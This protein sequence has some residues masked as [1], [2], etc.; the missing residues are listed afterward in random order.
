MTPRPLG[1]TLHHGVSLEHSNTEVVPREVLSEDSEPSA[2][3]D[4]YKEL[5]HSYSVRLL[6]HWI[7]LSSNATFHLSYDFNFLVLL[8]L[9]YWKVRPRITAALQARSRLTLRAME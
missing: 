2:R 9:I 6:A 4:E 1:R 3:N 8:A 7:R 5:T